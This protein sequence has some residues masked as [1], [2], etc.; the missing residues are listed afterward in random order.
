MT[1]KSSDSAESGPYGERLAAASGFTLPDADLELAIASVG[2]NLMRAARRIERDMESNFAR[3]AGLTFAGFWLMTALKVEGPAAPR[4]LAEL[5]S[6]STASVT[7]TLHT[8]ERAALIRRNP[9]LD[10]R[11]ML[12]ITLTEQGEAVVGEFM[13]WW[14]VNR[15][16]HWLE[17]LTRDEELTLARLLAKIAAH[18]P[19][20]LSEPQRRLIPPS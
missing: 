13:H 3:P 17:T 18:E 10:D 19:E 11:R 12:L 9:Q 8:L 2:M 15:E 16:K 14:T 20:P 4:R 6:V 1:D 5:L 7:S